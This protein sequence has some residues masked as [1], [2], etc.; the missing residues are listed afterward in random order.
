M[1]LL[2][3]TN[4]RLEPTNNM[5][6]MDSTEARKFMKLQTH[7]SCDVMIHNFTYLF[8]LFIY[9]GHKRRA[10]SSIRVTCVFCRITLETLFAQTTCVRASRNPQTVCIH[11]LGPQIHILDFHP[12]IQRKQ[13]NTFSK[14]QWNQT[15]A[16]CQMCCESATKISS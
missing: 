7:V 15:N 6:C 4:R 11:P 8:T 16:E 14:L 9:H 5:H 2:T 1:I 12:I 13:C 10:P 3:T